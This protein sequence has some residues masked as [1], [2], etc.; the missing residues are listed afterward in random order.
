MKQATREEYEAYFEHR[1]IITEAALQLKCE[2]NA[3][4]VVRCYRELEAKLAKVEAEIERLKRIKA[5]K[6][7]S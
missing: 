5:E 3:K 4:D 2:P 6:G 7:A 1:R